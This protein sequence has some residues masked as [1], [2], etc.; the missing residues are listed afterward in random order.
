MGFILPV[1]ASEDPAEQAKALIAHKDALE[2][3]L[4]SQ[5]S[6]LSANASTMNSPLLD[7]EGFPRSDIDVYAVRHAR[8]RIIELRNDVKGVMDMIAKALEGV[9]EAGHRASEEA[10]P[11]RDGRDSSSNDMEISRDEEAEIKPFARV[12]GVAPGSPASDAVS[13]HVPCSPSS[14]QSVQL[15]TLAE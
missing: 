11:S 2:D 6:V 4:N 7:S 15:T 5:Y 1:P 3:E 10:G 9:H 12:D 13:E 14:P 8:V